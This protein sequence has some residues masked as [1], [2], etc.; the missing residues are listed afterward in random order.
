MNVTQLSLYG[1]VSRRPA[2]DACM[3]QAWENANPS[4]RDAAYAIVEVIARERDEFTSDLVWE[5][6]SDFGFST[7]EPRAM[8]AV[9]RRAADAGLIQRTDRY[10]PTRRRAANRRPVAVWRSRCHTLLASAGGSNDW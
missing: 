10:V 7:H 5:R 1:Q 6:L 2:L 8:G 9:L 4:W 3:A